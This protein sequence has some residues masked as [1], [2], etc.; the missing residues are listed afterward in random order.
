MTLEKI[1]SWIK[2]LYSSDFQV[3]LRNR[4]EQMSNLEL[5][6]LLAGEGLLPEAT[7]LA[8]QILI[9]RLNLSLD[10][11]P[12]EVFDIEFNRLSSLSRVCHICGKGKPSQ[13]H[14][15]FMC[16]KAGVKVNWSHLISGAALNLIT[17]PAFG[18]GVL[19]LGNTSQKYQVVK[20]NLCLCDS[21][22]SRT[23]RITKDMCKNNPLV[24]LYML[25]GFD[26]VMWPSELEPC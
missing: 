22:A 6:N 13:N 3:E 24:E 7:D 20:L 4:Y 21:C 17:V 15:F 25:I 19:P 16:Q 1:T 18:T 2:N 23:K 8:R 11:T 5:A 12:S 10:F 26:D 9:E 14:E